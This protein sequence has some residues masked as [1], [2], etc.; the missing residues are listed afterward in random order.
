MSRQ[1]EVVLELSKR[2]PNADRSITKS[3]LKFRNKSYR[4][5]HYHYLFLSE[6][7]GFSN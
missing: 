7:G 6:F 4:G 1:S 3:S 5:S 2:S